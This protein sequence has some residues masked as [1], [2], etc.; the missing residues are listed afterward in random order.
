M[1]GPEYT[2][3]VRRVEVPAS[4]REFPA[5]TGRSGTQRARRPGGVRARC[6]A[7][8]RRCLALVAAVAVTAAVS[9][10]QASGVRT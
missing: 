1:L 4:D 9:S 8:G 3:V 7:A 10:Y 5:L 6:A 2:Q